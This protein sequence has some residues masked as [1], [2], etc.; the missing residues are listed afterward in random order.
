MI[1]SKY[2]HAA[3][4]GILSSIFLYLLLTYFQGYVPVFNNA[5]RIMLSVLISGYLIYRFIYRRL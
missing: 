1:D 3:I 4:I 5:V 2:L